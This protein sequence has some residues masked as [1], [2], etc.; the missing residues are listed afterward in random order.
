MF[1]A[2]STSF[3]AG[4]VEQWLAKTALAAAG[5]NRTAQSA[6]TQP[7]ETVGQHR[8]TFQR[9]AEE[10]AA[11]SGDV[12]AAQLCQHVQCVGRVADFLRCAMDGVD[13]PGKSLVRKARAP[14]RHHFDGLAQQ[15][16]GHGAGCRGVADAHLTGSQQA[17]A[18]FL[19]LPH[20]LDAPAD[21]STASALL[22]AGRR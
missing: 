8:H 13:F 22:I 12:E 18:R 1:R 4:S 17:D 14:A 21:G 7:D 19:L 15:H 2:S 11:E 9:T 3:A 5:Q 16:S 6:A 20:Q 10:D